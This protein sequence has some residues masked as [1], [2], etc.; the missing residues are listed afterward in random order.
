MG[1]GIEGRREEDAGT[2][3]RK[4][5]DKREGEVEAGSRDVNDRGLAPSESGRGEGEGEGAGEDGEGDEAGRGRGG[6]EG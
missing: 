2:D 5:M 1:R 6:R 4:G 3:K